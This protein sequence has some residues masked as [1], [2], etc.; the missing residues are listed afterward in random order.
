MGFNQGGITGFELGDSTSS[1]SSGFI[2]PLLNFGDTIYGLTGGVAT[3]LP[4]GS[5]GQIYAVNASLVPNWI[6]RVDISNYQLSYADFQTGNN[7]TS[8]GTVGEMN[9][10]ASGSG[11]GTPISVEGG[12]TFGSIS[13]PGVIAL[14]TGG[15]SAGVISLTHGTGGVNNLYLGG[16]PTILEV[17]LAFSAFSTTTDTYISSFGFM[18]AIPTL[19]GSI[20]GGNGAFFYYSSTL[21]SGNWIVSCFNA[22]TGTSVNLSVGPTVYTTGYQKLAVI[23]N[24][25]I[26]NV[27]F[28]IGG[29][30][31]ATISTN[32]PATSTSIKSVVNISKKG[33]STG[34][35]PTYAC[36][37]AIRLLKILSTP[38]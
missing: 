14:S 10:W 31:Q 12:I 38:R 8:N 24:P 15:S 29:S 13:N 35:T 6:D 21:N 5:I 20:N 32:L 4:V 25:I 34:I 36:V 30:L 26:P 7:A 19:A 22:T 33:G 16:S 23:Y 17:I 18:D 3:N 2:S 37:D 27:G 28:Y 11:T 9:W 1:G